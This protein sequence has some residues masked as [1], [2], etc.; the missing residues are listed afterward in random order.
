MA[1]MHL[2]DTRALKDVPALRQFA[3]LIGIAVAV[4]AG[5]GIWSWSQRPGYVPVFANL[6]DRDAGELAEALRSA[7]IP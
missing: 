1:I 2:P 5:I 4:A 6:S 3:V 7:G